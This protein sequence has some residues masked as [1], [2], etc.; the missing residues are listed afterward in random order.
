MTILSFISE[1]TGF[2]AILETTA[3]L[4]DKVDMEPVD[5]PNLIE[6]LD[7]RAVQ[8]RHRPKRQRTRLSLLAATAHELE[9]K[10]YEALTIDGIVRR[11]G[12]ARGTFYLYFQNR[13][14]A[15][16]AVRRSFTATLRKFRPRGAARLSRW[17]AIYRMNRFYVA[18]YA[19]NARLLAGTGALFHE[20][21]DLMRSRDAINHRWALILLRDIRRREPDSWLQQVDETQTLLALRF[22]ILMTDEALRLVYIDPPPRISALSCSEVQVT[23]TLTVLWYNCLYADIPRRA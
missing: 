1:S 19:R 17:E 7:A 16:T 11:A 20:R 6:I 8:A 4:S 9:E 12:L 21:P 5:A 22:V 10:G 13:A 14:E 18:F 2:C 3:G 15:A 23:E